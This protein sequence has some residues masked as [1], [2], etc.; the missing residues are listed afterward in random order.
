MLEAWDIDYKKGISMRIAN[1]IEMLS[2]NSQYGT[3]YPTVI[4]D[5]ND[6]ILFDAGNAKESHLLE[7]ALAEIGLSLNKVNKIIFTHQDI[8][9]V[10]GAKEIMYKYG[11]KETFAH[12]EETEYING[13]ATPDSLADLEQTYENLPEDMQ[14]M[15]DTLRKAYKVLAFDIDNV[16]DHGDVISH[17]GGIEVI[18]TPGH[19][20]GHICLYLKESKVLVAGDLLNIINDSINPNR[21]YYSVKLQDGALSG[22]NSEYTGDMKLAFNS[23]KKLKN[24][25]IEKIVT[26]HSG[27][28]EGDIK[29]AID[30]LISDR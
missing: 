17:C 21:D 1:N 13:T 24:Y 20:P 12:K 8:D 23:I 3:V 25:D 30:N 28:F 19:T 26:F 6:V 29:T 7:E 9:H 2:I 10:G 11:N 4:W 15:Y 22:P 5:D 18:F 27:L 16:L 14:I